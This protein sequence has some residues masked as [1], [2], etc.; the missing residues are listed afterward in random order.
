MSE[1]KEHWIDDDPTRKAFWAYCKDTLGLDESEVYAAL[2]VDSIHAFD[3]DKDMARALLKSFDVN[4]YRI[5]QNLAPQDPCTDNPRAVAFLDVFA[6]DGTR[7][8]LTA[9]EG[10]TADTVALTALALWDG[11]QILARLGWTLAAENGKQAAARL[12]PKAQEQRPVPTGG[13]PPPPTPPTP[14]VAQGN[15]NGNGGG[16]LL[17]EFVKIT[18]PKGKPVIEFWRPNR[19]YSEIRWYLG[20]EAFIEQ[21]APTLAAAGWT[22]EHFDAIGQEYTLPLKIVWE[23]SPKDA[24]YKD[25]TAVT[26]R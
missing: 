7:I 3:G 5:I 1:K 14:E 19:Q 17:T 20:G 15:G 16:E 10:A 4:S 23:P 26:L 24:K 25:I 13:P 11:A 6:P 9:R 8:A 21:V 18:A 22:A 12:Q 2:S